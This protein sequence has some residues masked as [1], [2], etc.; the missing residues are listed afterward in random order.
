[1]TTEE[2]FIRVRRLISDVTGVPEGEITMD[3]VLADIAD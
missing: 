1:M 3:T 2:I